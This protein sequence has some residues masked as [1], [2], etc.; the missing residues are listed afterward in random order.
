MVMGGEE[1]MK[2]L[3]DVFSKKL[4]DSDQKPLFEGTEE[5]KGIKSLDSKLSFESILEQAFKDIEDFPSAKAA[6]QQFKI[7]DEDFDGIVQVLKKSMIGSKLFKLPQIKIAMLKIN[8]IR[9]NIV[10]DKDFN[11]TDEQN[12]EKSLYER[13]GKI[14]G[15]SKIMQSVFKSIKQ[16]EELF[17]FY[18]DKD[19]GVVQKRYA[20]YIAGQ[21]GGRF[22]WMG[23]DLE[24]CHK[25]VND[26][27]YEKPEN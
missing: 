25:A 16:D 26:A 8:I 14:E 6:Y 11:A 2:K 3:I 22:D 7:S 23:Q 18:K 1:S 12:K 27:N 24:V 21:I 15:L 5:H 19:L 13:M 20:Y 10:F 9:E 4:E 17:K